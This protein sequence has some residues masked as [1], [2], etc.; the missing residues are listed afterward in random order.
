M[1]V[2]FFLESEDSKKEK[3]QNHFSFIA[4]KNKLFNLIVSNNVREERFLVGGR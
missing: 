2:H 1:P 4:P 3:S